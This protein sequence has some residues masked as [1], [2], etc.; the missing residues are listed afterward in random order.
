MDIAALISS[1]GAVLNV[2]VA[3]P[4]Y[5]MPAGCI[6]VRVNGTVVSPGDSYSNGVFVRAPVVTVP[7]SA[8]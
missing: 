1:S 8:V 7:A 2:I 6:L 5:P 4:E 3:G